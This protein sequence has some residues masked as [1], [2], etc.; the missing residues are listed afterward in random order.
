MKLMP[1][2]SVIL[3]N[4]DRIDALEYSF[5]YFRDG[6]FFKLNISIWPITSYYFYG[7][8]DIVSL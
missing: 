3:E 7:E 4:F 1:L 6:I 2:I 8:L 5:L